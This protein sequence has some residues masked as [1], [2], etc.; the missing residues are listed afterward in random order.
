MNA[1]SHKPSFQQILALVL[2]IIHLS[3]HCIFMIRPILKINH[4]IL[5]FLWGINFLLLGFVGMDYFII[6]CGDPAD[7]LLVHPEKV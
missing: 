6:T 1:Y 3:M 5:F 4:P 7:E 2:F